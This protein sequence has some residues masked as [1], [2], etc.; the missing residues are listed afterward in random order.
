MFKSLMKQ[1]IPSGTMV[2]FLDLGASFE[3]SYA[4][5]KVNWNVEAMVPWRQ[6]LQ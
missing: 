5:R 3:S 2:I 4:N 6:H 1:L